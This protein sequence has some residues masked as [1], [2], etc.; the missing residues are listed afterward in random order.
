[1]KKRTSKKISLGMV[2]TL[3]MAS[4]LNLMILF[5]I[6]SF[7]PITPP[8][9]ANSFQMA[10]PYEGTVYAVTAGN[11]LISFN[12]ITPGAIIRTVPISG[13]PQ[14]ETIVSIDF[15]PRTGQLYGLGSASRIYTINT[16]NGAATPAG[17]AFTPALNGTAFGV[18]FN[19][20]HAGIGAIDRSG[21]RN[22]IAAG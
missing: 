7:A 20:I 2:T 16:I 11:N 12:A 17:P 15:R 9:N 13:L 3:G 1:M 6:G 4:V 14:G 5:T 8:V 19:P 18:D 22:R 10:E 21:S